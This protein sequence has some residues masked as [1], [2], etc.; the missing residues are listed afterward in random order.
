M[1]AQINNRIGRQ[2]ILV[3]MVLSFIAGSYAQKSAIALNEGSNI[4]QLNSIIELLNNI[5][6]ND[7]IPSIQVIGINDTELG[8][9]ELEFDRIISVPEFSTSNAFILSEEEELEVEDWMLDESHFRISGSN[10]GMEEAEEKLEVEDWMLDE[11]HFLSGEVKTNSEEDLAEDEL[12][13]EN[14]MLDPNHWASL[15]D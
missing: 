11:S 5:E 10:Y 12:Q 6:L 4:K 9:I 7:A 8:S 3:L 2:M 13:I 1:K 14:W 15:A